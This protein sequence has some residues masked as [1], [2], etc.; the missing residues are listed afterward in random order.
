[1]ERSYVMTLQCTEIARTMQRIL[2]IIARRRM[3]VAGGSFTKGGRNHEHQC[4][5][6]VTASPG[7]MENL[8]RMVA[9]QVEVRQVRYAFKSEAG[10]P[11]AHF[12]QKYTPSFT[13]DR[14]CSPGVPCG[15]DPYN[16]PAARA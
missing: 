8:S 7:E 15:G 6:T 4:A 1:M 3:A 11:A 5:I 10:R 14:N 12:D 9:K 13:A 2:G 16:S